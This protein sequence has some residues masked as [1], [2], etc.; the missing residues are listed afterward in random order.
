MGVAKDEGERGRT[1]SVKLT[2]CGVAG[3]INTEGTLDYWE[4]KDDYHCLY[5]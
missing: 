1:A 3:T 5:G 4:V 2:L